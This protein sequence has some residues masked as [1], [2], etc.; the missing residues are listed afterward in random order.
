MVLNAPQEVLDHMAA[1]ATAE[2]RLGRPDDVAQVVAFLAEEGSRWINGQSH[3]L[4]PFT[5]HGYYM[6]CCFSFVWIEIP[7]AD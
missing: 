6:F 3:T 7:F 4:S 5:Q 2:H 1:S